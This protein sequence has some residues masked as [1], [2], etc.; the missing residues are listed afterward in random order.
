[1]TGKV[2]ATMRRHVLAGMTGIIV[3]FTASLP[4][5]AATYPE[6]AIRIIVPVAAGGSTDLVA[7][8]FQMTIERLKLLPQPLVIVNNAA[9]GGTVGTRMIKDAEPDGYTLGIWHMGLLTA[10]AMGVT[11]YDH[12]AFDLVAQVGAIEVGLAVKSDSKIASLKELVAEAKARPG[13]VSAAM[14]I[15]LLPHFVPLMFA[16]EAGIDFRWVQAGGGSVRLRSVLGNHTEFSLFSVPEFVTFGPQGIR[17]LV[18]FSS[19][20]HPRVANVPTA[21]ELGYNFTFSEAILWLA[22]RGTPKDRVDVVAKAIEAS[23]RDDDFKKRYDEQGIDPAYIPGDKLKAVLDQRMT[24][25][26][27]VAAQVKAAKTN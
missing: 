8:I 16:S 3:A 12:T 13:Q 24:G 15:G 25:I 9:A 4:A 6:K 23:M 1:M 27:A 21:A 19:A 2:G 7:R 26:K 18:V 20:R 11:D 10:A 17:P 5:S 14:N 22:P